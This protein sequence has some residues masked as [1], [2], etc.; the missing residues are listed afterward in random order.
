MNSS[1]LKTEV[2]SFI[3]EHL[4]DD[5]SKVAL[6]KSPFYDVSSRELAEQIDSKKRS[7]KKLPLWFNTPNIYFPSKLSIEQSSSALTA[8]YKSRLV[9]G[10]SLIDLTGGFGV[11]AFYFSKAVR[12]VTHC[13]QNEDLSEIAKHNAE[14]LGAENI[15]FITADSIS[16]LLQNNK[17]YDTVYVDPSRRIQSKKVFL[18]KDTEP[19]VVSNLSLL[20]ARS[21]RIIVKTSPL[22]DI[23]SGLK[24]LGNVSEIHIVSVKNDCKELLWIIDKGFEAEPEIIC[25]AIGIETESS[26]QFKLS[27]EKNTELKTFS[28]PLRYLYEPDV[29]IMKAGAFKSVAN[30][31]DVQ[32]IHPNSHLYTSNHF[33]AEFMGK[34]FQ[35]I[36]TFGY[37]DFQKQ[38]LIK[39]ANI[40]SRNFPKTP[41]ELKKK[42]KLIDG[43]SDFLIFTTVEQDKLV[44]VHAVLVIK[45]Y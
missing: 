41:E 25:K 20:L 15:Q 18:L 40:I 39:K 34:K 29:S 7:K 3:A 19:D 16:Y 36:N 1:I 28:E 30:K 24:E 4:Q 32:K 17:I 44:V 2:Q 45:Q 10:E 26:F 8:E 37:G 31:Y 23:S 14:Q 9:K 35:I 12:K 27:S 13:E 43:G 38:N 21:K 5:V 6:G 11:D 42:H 22:F 33:S